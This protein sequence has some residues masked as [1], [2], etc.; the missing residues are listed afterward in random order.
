MLANQGIQVVRGKFRKA[1]T[2][3]RLVTTK[4][5]EVV[6]P[7]LPSHWGLTQRALSFSA[8]S[9]S[10]DLPKAQVWKMEEK[11]SDVNLA[12]YLLRDAFCGLKNALVISGDSDLVTPVR[13]SVEAG[14]NVKVVVPNRYIE[15]SSLAK[16][17]T[18]L[19]RMQPRLLSQH[20]MDRV[21]LTRSGGNIVRPETWV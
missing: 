8:G 7:M 2:W 1:E 19:E 16:V 13:F 12:A 20:Q 10:P 3:L 14:V 15:S 11:G 5:E 21:F 17:A 9:I 18:S 4:R 6:S